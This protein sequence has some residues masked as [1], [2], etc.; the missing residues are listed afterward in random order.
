MRREHAQH[1][2]AA[3][4]RT[5]A[6]RR[7]ARGLCL[8]A[9]PREAAYKY[10]GS[11]RGQTRSG[12]EEEWL[13]GLSVRQLPQHTNEEEF[14]RGGSVVAKLS[15]QPVESHGCS[16][17]VVPRLKQGVDWRLGGAVFRPAKGWGQTPAVRR[18]TTAGRSEPPEHGD[19]PRT[20]PVAGASRRC[21]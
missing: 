15:V 8:R 17:A 9:L 20:S 5:T 21:W 11:D 2:R 19:G 1:A 13:R 12:R 7:G 16:F 6:C 10:F 3:R 4:K 18:A 14:V